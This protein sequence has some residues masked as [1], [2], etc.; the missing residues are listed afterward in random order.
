MKYFFLFFLYS[1]SAFALREEDVIRSVLAHFPLIE[2]AQLKASQ[3]RG[4]MLSSEGA[5]DHK[6]SFKS[7]N[8]I[9]DNYDN[10][11][12]ETTLER[13]TPIGGT[14]L[15]AG[16]RQGLG[17]FPFYDGKYKTSGAG[18]IFA[19]LSVPI[20]RNFKTD[21]YRTNL[22]LKQIEV[23]QA[24]EQLKLKKLIYVH[25]ALS[26]YFKWVLE[27]QKLKINKSMFN[28]AQLRHEMIEKKFRAGDVEKM[29][30]VD[31][32]RTI[33]KRQGEIIKNEIDLSKLRTELSLYVRD[34][35]GNPL[36]V[37][38]EKYSDLILSGPEPTIT[39]SA[40]TS[41]N[42]Q[43]KLLNLEKEKLEAELRFHEQSKLPGLNVDLMGARELSQN[44]A[45]D[46]ESLQLGIRFDFPLENRKGKG[47]SV[48]T[49]YKTKAL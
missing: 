5:F 37:T 44:A 29:K 36:L 25:K 11:Y 41:E 3:S 8:R 43:L 21:E 46:P 9:E 26:L 17:H 22:L 38:E 27:T 15:I 40:R 32:L 16:H 42:P 39:L 7:R 19:G 47:K 45:Y 30:I 49:E 1:V 33:D 31:N 23:K 2:E 13:Q 6:L 20:L 34:F 24:D 14:S 4:E 48:A 28:L 18:E 12:F 10:Q 35:E